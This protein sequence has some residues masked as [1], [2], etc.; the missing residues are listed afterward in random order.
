MKVT[1]NILDNDKVIVHLEYTNQELQQVRQ[2]CLERSMRRAM[3]KQIKNE[4]LRLK[5]AETTEKIRQQLEERNA[6]SQ[7]QVYELTD[8][9]YEEIFYWGEE[10]ESEE[11]KE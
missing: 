10:E 2:D 5:R 9:D 7:P 6:K 11:Y 3:D 8:E 4:E 1:R